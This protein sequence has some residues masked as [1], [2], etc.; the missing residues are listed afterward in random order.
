MVR[1]RTFQ[2]VGAIHIH[3]VSVSED[4]SSHTGETAIYY[5]TLVLDYEPVKKQKLYFLSQEHELLFQ[6]WLYGV[7]SVS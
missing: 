3:F 6:I 1:I 2:L 5:R 4:H 7:T